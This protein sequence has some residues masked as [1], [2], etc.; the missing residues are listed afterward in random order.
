[1]GWKEFLGF[2]KTKLFIMIALFVI[3]VL[4]AVLVGHSFDLSQASFIFFPLQ[5][6]YLFD[7]LFRVTVED[8]RSCIFPGCNIVITIL[9]FVTSF[10]I[11][12]TLSSIV[13]YFWKKRA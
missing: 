2:N 4:L 10:L 9:T 8:F 1:M 3:T 6:T 11:Y 13:Y 5:I 7:S 12:H